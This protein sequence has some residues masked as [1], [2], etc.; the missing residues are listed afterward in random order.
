MPD[1]PISLPAGYAPAFAIGY[2]AQDGQ[3]AVVDDT[4]PLPVSF[5]TSQP[6]PVV[7]SGGPAPAPLAGQTAITTTAGP[8]APA[9]GRPVF[10]TLSGTWEGSVQ[11]ERSTNGG[12][13]RHPLTV[14]GLPWGGFTANACEPVW[15]E[16]EA[17]VE[18][19]LAIEIA[20]GTLDYRVSQ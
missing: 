18:L 19:Y 6:I 10:V 8:F 12:A 20:S 7:T 5:A 1:Q 2:A 16:N 9:S 11:V 4:K 14:A 15:V 13:T 3:L 17:G